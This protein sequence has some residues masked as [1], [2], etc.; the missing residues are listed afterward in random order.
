MEEAI[1]GHV[2]RLLSKRRALPTLDL[3]KVR[4]NSSVEIIPISAGCLGNC[5]YCKTKHA[6]GALNSYSEDAIVGRALRAASEGV[7]EVWL[8]SEDT[9]AYGLDIGTNIA[10]LL[11]RVSKELPP[12]VMMKL[13]MTN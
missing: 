10:S 6:R 12:G 2:I 3:P 4:R 11:G 9:G 7:S 8:T 1:R 13:G 5:S